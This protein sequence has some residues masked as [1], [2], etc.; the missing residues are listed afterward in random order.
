MVSVFV[1]HG[2]YPSGFW[3]ETTGSLSLALGVLIKDGGWYWVVRK[4]RFMGIPLPLFLF[5]ASKAYKRIHNGQYEFS[6]SFALPFLGTLVSY[7]GLLTAR[8]KIA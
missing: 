5:P 3:R 7:S 1:P 6:V 8:A 2:H 4:V